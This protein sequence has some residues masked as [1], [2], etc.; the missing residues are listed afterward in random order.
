MREMLNQIKNYNPGYKS[1]DIRN[2]ENIEMI[3]RKVFE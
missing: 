2:I 1:T 3:E